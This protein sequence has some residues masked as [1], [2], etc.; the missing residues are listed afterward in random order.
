MESLAVQWLRLCTCIAQETENLQGM[1]GPL[2]QKKS[3]C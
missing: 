2:L 1:G 3:F